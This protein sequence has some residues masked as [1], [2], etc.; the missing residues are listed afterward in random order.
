MEKDRKRRE[1]E[2]CERCKREMK[3]EIERM[4]EGVNA[5]SL[6]PEWQKDESTRR[7]HNVRNFRS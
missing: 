5:A 6:R 2:K 7:L 3:K 1:R 4:D